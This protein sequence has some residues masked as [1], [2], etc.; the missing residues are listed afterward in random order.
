M[1]AV[2]VDCTV[3]EALVLMQARARTS[4]QTLYCVAS[5]VVAGHIRF[6]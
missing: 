3:E 6:D 1:I 4:V 2:Q 5:A